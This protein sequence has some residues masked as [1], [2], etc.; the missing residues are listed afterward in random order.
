MYLFTAY[1][2]ILETIQLMSE[3]FAYFFDPQNYIETIQI[4]FNMYFLVMKTS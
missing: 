3:G 1:S 2:L 4:G